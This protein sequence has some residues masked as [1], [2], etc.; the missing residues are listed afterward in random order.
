MYEIGSGLLQPQPLDR[1]RQRLAMNGPID[2]VP[3]VRR[4]AGDFS[5]AIEI[6]LLVE[7]AVNIIAHPVQTSLIG[8]P[9]YLLVHAEPFAFCSRIGRP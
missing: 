2:P 3:V 1:C 5:E 7:M 8:R 9:A 6:E 4:Q